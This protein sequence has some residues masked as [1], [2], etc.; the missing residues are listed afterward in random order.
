MYHAGNAL[1]PS[2]SVWAYYLFRRLRNDAGS[3]GKRLHVG[4][5]LHGRK[6]PNISKGAECILDL[7]EKHDLATIRKAFENLKKQEEN[8]PE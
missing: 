1:L 2:M 5:P 8:P 3:T 7:A 6:I 4:M